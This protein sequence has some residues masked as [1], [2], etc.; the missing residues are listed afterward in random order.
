MAHPSC[1]ILARKH[2]TSFAF[3]HMYRFTIKCWRQT[4]LTRGMLETLG[5]ARVLL[6]K[7]GFAF[8][9]VLGDS[10]PQQLVMLR[11]NRPANM[12]N[13]AP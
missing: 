10:T 9:A 8:H 1:R 13:G 11:I 7:Y 5:C 12:G 6:P 4:P 2:I 3:D